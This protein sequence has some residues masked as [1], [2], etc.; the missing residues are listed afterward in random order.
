M[1]RW[2]AVRSPGNPLLTVESEGM[3]A[4][5]GYA[6]V[7]GPS[8][9]R[10]PSW[11]EAP[12]GRYYMYFAHHRGSFMRLAYA[13]DVDGPWTVWKEGVLHLQDTPALDHIAS[14]DVH[15]DEA[16]Q[17]IRMYYHSVEDTTSWWQS[18]FAATSADGLHFK[19]GYESLGPPYMRVFKMGATWW[20]IA[21]VRGGPGGVL[22]RAK[23]PEGP[24]HGGPKI[25]PGMRHATVMVIGNLAHV[26]FSRIGDEPER[27]L[28][29]EFDPRKRWIDTSDT[30]PVD[31]LW[32][33]NK[34][35]GT[36]MPMSR[37]EVGEATERVRALRDPY[38]FSE[39]G[40]HFLFYSIAGESGIA[41]ARI[42]VPGPSGL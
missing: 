34:Y 19:S 22:L 1:P 11:I 36:D 13:D 2:N 12:L 20:A 40:E 26:V 38:V 21:K 30:S 6:N 33:Q 14:P 18:T 15:V 17:T 8:V 23:Q 10:V 9:I 42:T 32:S 24:F 5:H 39:N 28:R 29:T 7:N 41:M 4:E 31:V 37:S 27:L 16:N 3:V 35:E 25:L